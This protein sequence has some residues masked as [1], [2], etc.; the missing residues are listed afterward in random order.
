MLWST[1]LNNWSAGK[2]FTYPKKIKDKFQWQTSKISAIKNLKYTQKFIIDKHLPDIQEYKAF[3]PYFKKG[4]FVNFLSLSNNMLIV[5][6]PKKNYNYA[7]I[8]DFID[9]TK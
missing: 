4:Q 7:T 9:N 8:K 3:V 1:V 2:P 5:P 6:I